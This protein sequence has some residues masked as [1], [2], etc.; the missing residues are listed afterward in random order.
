MVDALEDQPAIPFRTPSGVTL[1]RVNAATGRRAQ[2]G[3]RN[4]IWEP[5][6]PGTEPDAN[7]NSFVVEGSSTAV[8]P[9]INNAPSDLPLALPTLGTGGLY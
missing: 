5:F 6:K 9:R 2:P 8:A 7:G 3:D 1:V 4:A